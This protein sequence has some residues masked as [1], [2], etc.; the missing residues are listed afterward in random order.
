ML[1]KQIALQD[2]ESVVSAIAWQCKITA[3]AANVHE[4]HRVHVFAALSGQRIFQFTQVD[5]G[6]WPDRFG[7]EVHHWWRSLRTGRFS[8]LFLAQSQWSCDLTIWFYLLIHLIY[9]FRLIS[10]IWSQVAQRSLSPMTTRR[11]TSSKYLSRSEI[12]CTVNDILLTAL[13]C[14]PVWWC[15]GG[16]WTGCWSKWLP[17][18]R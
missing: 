6:E 8:G 11:N 3:K 1:Q 7:F 10:T 13:F 12:K 4:A 2:M 17:S 9:P 18:K 14:F 16:L 15:S 5:F